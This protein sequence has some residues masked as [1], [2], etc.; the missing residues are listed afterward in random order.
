MDIKS[1]A[2]YQQE[3]LA[4]LPTG[5][6]WPRDG[7]LADLLNGMAAELARH[8]ARCADLLNEADPAKTR[9]LLLEWE[10][11]AG[12]PS[13]CMALEPQT[14]VDRRRAL[15]ARLTDSGGQRPADFIALAAIFGCAIT[16]TEFEPWSCNSP[17]SQPIRGLDWR[18]AWQVNMP[19]DSSNRQYWSC[20]SPVSEPLSS[21]GNR[22]VECM[23]RHKAPAHTV[24]IFSYP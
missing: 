15:I 16:I 9:E 17:V 24:V 7:L 19:A 6:A 10:A 12:L 23:I 11:W 8:D 13:P 4:L 5:A 21:W 20:A 3:L 2:D 18:F 14:V 1:Q 22:I